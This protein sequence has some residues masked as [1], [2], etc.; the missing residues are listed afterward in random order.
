MN[1]YV[2]K[3][4]N[5]VGKKKILHTFTK[6]LLKRHSQIK[7]AYIEL[8]VVEDILEFLSMESCTIEGLFEF[9]E[10]KTNINIQPLRE[11]PNIEDVRQYQHA[12]TTKSYFYEWYCYLDNCLRRYS[13]ALCSKQL[14]SNFLIKYKKYKGISLDLRNP[15]RF[16]KKELS[17]IVE[18]IVNNLDEL[19]KDFYAGRYETVDL[20]LQMLNFHDKTIERED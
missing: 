9:L 1:E 19:S 14:L 6:T 7:S 3:K 18:S 10:N 4:L 16:S 11:S 17:F 20:F 5:N 15:E 13:S 2:I 8:K 12:K